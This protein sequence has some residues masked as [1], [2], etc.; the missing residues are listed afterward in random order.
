MFQAYDWTPFDQQA[1]LGQSQDSNP[2]LAFI[3]LLYGY[4][5]TSAVHLNNVAFYESNPFHTLSKVWNFF[6]L[7]ERVLL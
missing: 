5:P 1:G 2:L 4:S 6:L 3:F 7:F